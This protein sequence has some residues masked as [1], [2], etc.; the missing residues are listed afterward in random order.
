[1]CEIEHFVKENEKS[2]PK[3]VTV[4]D[5]KLPLFPQEQQLGSGKV[6]S[7]TVILSH[8]T[9]HCLAFSF[10]RALSVRLLSTASS[11]TRRSVTSSV[12]R[13]CS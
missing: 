3:F 9:T 2:H 5:I 7:L 12:A 4:K 6:S 8:R 13:I 1:M 11:P 10:S